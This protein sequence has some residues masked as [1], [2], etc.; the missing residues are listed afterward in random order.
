MSMDFRV[1]RIAKMTGLYIVAYFP[2]GGG[3]GESK[4]LEMGKGIKG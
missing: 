2:L 4:D 3:G 1:E